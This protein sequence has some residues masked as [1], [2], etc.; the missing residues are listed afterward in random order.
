MATSG[1]LKYSISTTLSNCYAG[2]EF[3]FEFVSEY[4]PTS[5]NWTGSVSTG[6]LTVDIQPVSI[7]GYPYATSSAD[8]GNFVYSVQPPNV[9]V[10]NTILS[11]FTDDYRQ[12][13]FYAI[14]P[15]ATP[16]FQNSLYTT[17]GNITQAFSPKFN[18][19][20][21][22]KSYDGRV[23]ILTIRTVSNIANVLQITVNPDLDVYFQNNPDQISELLIVKKLQDEQNIIIPLDIKFGYTGYG[24][25]I[26]EDITLDV[27]D[28]I[29]TIQ[30]NVQTQLL[31]QQ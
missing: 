2:D 23:Q 9:L 25:T 4:Q 19:K 28:K 15:D 12:I 14:S 5:G 24:F 30:S 31:S 26:P 22:I 17:Y 21:V 10:F 7:G 18:D 11:S 3:T 20:I 13:P 16:E 1:S 27:L 8:Y 6:S 29:S